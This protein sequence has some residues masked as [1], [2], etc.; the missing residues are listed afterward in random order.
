M[1]CRAP[2]LDSC[3]TRGASGEWPAE[4]LGDDVNAE[5]GTS[6]RP[7]RVWPWMLAVGVL[8]ILLIVSLT[9]HSVA[10]APVAVAPV[11]AVPTS[12]TVYAPFGYATVPNFI[13]MTG[14]QASAA[15]TAADLRGLDF[16]RNYAAMSSRVVSQ[17][18]APG[19]N[20]NKIEAVQLTLDPSTAATTT[21]APPPTT[22]YT[23]PSTEWTYKVTGRNAASITYSSEDGGTSQVTEADLPWSKKIDSP[24]F[25]G[26]SF[27]YVS[28]QNSGGGTI[29]C[30]IIDPS[31]AVVAENSSEG[32]YAIV[33]CQD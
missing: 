14:D 17:Y 18:P 23:P 8:A 33:T 7:R 6:P 3:T 2:G 27:A 22:T 25:A 5:K 28:A 30:Q 31:G 15:A 29:S 9:Q 16:A 10:P 11:A 26:M 12:S 19:T 4:D 13:G 24:S 20:W 21:Y 1:G 32:A